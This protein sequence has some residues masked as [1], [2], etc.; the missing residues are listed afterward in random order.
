MQPNPK[1]VELVDRINAF[2]ESKERDELTHRALEREIDSMKKADSAIAFAMGGMLSA[3]I[4]D[5][6]EARKQFEAARR[7]R[8]D[9]SWIELNYSKALYNL[10]CARDARETARAIF[11]RNPDDLEVLDELIYLT[12]SSARVLEANELIARRKQL[13]PQ[14]EHPSAE[15]IVELG[16]FYRRYNLQADDVEAL[17]ELTLNTLHDAGYHHVAD[18]FRVAQ[19]GDSEWFSWSLEVAEPIGTVVDLN[20]LLAESMA[21]IKVSPELSTSFNIMYVP[22]SA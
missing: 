5:E 8:P 11:D 20:A 3:A 4:F 1:A 14:E 12:L 10:G 18:K 6:P 22:A 2:A 17:L 9:D 19:D 21:T 7:L 16:S 15:I 13:K